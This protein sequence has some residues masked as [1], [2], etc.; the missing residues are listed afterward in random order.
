[1]ELSES[2]LNNTNKYTSGGGNLANPNPEMSPIVNLQ[3][4]NRNPNQRQA[5]SREQRKTPTK[6]YS[7]NEYDTDSFQDQRNTTRG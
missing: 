6:N 4:Q 5:Y 7:K 3:R 2:I 1:M